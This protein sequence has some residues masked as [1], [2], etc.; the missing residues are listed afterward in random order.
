MR[1]NRRAARQ[2]KL[3]CSNKFLAYVNK[4]HAK[5]SPIYSG[6][7]ALPSRVCRPE[8]GPP[9]Y[10]DGPVRNTNII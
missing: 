4:P 6:Q 7:P 9:L 2:P 8:L 1:K 10:H 3:A 5:Q